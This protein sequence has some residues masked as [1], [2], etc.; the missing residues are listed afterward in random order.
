M[1]RKTW[2][3]RPGVFTSKDKTAIRGL[4]TVAPNAAQIFLTGE[5]ATAR[6]SEDDR[7]SLLYANNT[8][9]HPLFE[10]TGQATI[11][12]MRFDARQV[13]PVLLQGQLVKMMVLEARRFGITDMALTKFCFYE[14]LIDVA[15]LTDTYVTY[16]S[17]TPSTVKVYFNALTMFGKPMLCGIPVSCFF[18][19]DFDLKADRVAASRDTLKAR[20]M[21]RDSS[22]FAPTSSEV[23]FLLRL[24]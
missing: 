7:W 5:I 19:A 2:T 17:P 1:D 3:Y 18:S 23:N 21:A 6:L 11:R 16:D 24:S 12:M 22:H 4:A 20:D 14:S 10:E 9:E 15:G 13:W 8:V